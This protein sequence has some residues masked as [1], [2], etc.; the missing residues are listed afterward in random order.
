MDVEP[1]ARGYEDKGMGD[2]RQRQSACK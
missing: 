2:L 1:I